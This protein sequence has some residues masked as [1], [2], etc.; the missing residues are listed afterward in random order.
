MRSSTAYALGKQSKAKHS[1]Q[2]LPRDFCLALTSK[3]QKCSQQNGG[4]EFPLLEL[5]LFGL[6]WEWMEADL[7]K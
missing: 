6:K 1:W 2:F 4:S 7:E 5:H 3:L